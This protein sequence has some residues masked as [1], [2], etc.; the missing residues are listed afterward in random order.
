MNEKTFLFIIVS[1]V[2]VAF[3]VTLGYSIIGYTRGIESELERSKATIAEL[4][5]IAEHARERMARETEFLEQDRA[6]IERE[7]DRLAT[8]RVEL[9]RTRS[10]FEADRKRLDSDKDTHK[11]LAELIEKSIELIEAGENSE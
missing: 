3:F 6:E 2:I 7:R 11:R 4:E 1:F 8:E 10:I 5:L 9:E